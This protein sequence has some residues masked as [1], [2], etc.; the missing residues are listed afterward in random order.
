MEKIRKN[1]LEATSI[2]IF[3]VRRASRDPEAKMKP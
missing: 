3:E 1:G 2:N